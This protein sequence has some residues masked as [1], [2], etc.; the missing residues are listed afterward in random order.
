MT[1]WGKF[2]NVENRLR[3]VALGVPE[4]RI[5]RETK[6]ILR[7]GSLRAGARSAVGKGAHLAVIGSPEEPAVMSLGAGSRIGARSRINVRNGLSIGENCEFSW[8]VQILDSDFHTMEYADGRRSNATKP[9]RIGNHVL[10]GTG[11]I[12]LK[13]VTIGDGAVIGA[14]S[15]VSKDVPAN[16]IVSGN[17]ARVQRD[18]VSWV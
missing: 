11:A 18:I 7:H 4:C 17:P 12:I 1:T 15:V 6:I 13:G 10:I 5:D 3:A 16:V 9:I 8:L 14:G 2:R